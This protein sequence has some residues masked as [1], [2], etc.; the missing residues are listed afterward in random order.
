MILSGGQNIYPVDLESVMI[1]HPAV[2]EVAIIGVPH[3]IW[4]ETPQALVVLKPGFD[5][6][7]S[8]E[9]LAFANQR[10][11]KRQRI[12]SITVREDLPRN[13]N[14]KILKRLLRAEFRK[15]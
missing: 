1:Q 2:S 13:P 15:G 6:S 10:L 12:S 4:G 8:D 9:I 5:P 7:V 14:G 3:E 11:G